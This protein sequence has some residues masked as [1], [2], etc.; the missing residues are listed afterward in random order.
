MANLNEGAAHR[1]GQ[2]PNPDSLA[3]AVDRLNEGAAHRYG[4]YPNPDSVARAVDRL[5]CMEQYMQSHQDTL[6]Q[7]LDMWRNLPVETKEAWEDV[8]H[9]KSIFVADAYGVRLATARSCL[10]RVC[11]TLVTVN[12]PLSS[13]KSAHRAIEGLVAWSRWR[14]VASAGLQEAGHDLSLTEKWISRAL[15]DWCAG[16]DSLYN[17]SSAA[18]DQF[19]Q[20][21]FPAC[22]AL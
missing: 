2:Y 20:E 13:P 7:L 14:A 16:A 10:L 8:Y 19:M 9:T 3:R 15:Y 11:P 12:G 4:E 22:R 6:V 21:P 5:S 17:L 1:Y 18:Y